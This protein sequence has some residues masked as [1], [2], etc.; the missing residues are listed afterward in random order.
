MTSPTDA[1]N[2]GAERPLEE[3]EAQIVRIKPRQVSNNGNEYTAVILPDQTWVFVWDPYWRR[4]IEQR[5]GLYLYLDA[6]LYVRDK[7]EVDDA[8]S[9]YWLEAVLP[10]SEQVAK[11]FLRRWERDDRQRLIAAVADYT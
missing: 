3:L 4:E 7:S 11:Q 1:Q 5:L 8:E 6:R 10:Q 2:G 9:F